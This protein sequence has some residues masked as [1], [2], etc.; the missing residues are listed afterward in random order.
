MP[1]GVYK[2]IPGV[3]SGLNKGKKFTD[4]QK[5]RLSEIAK[6]KGFGK[7]MKGKVGVNKGKVFSKKWREN[8]S[9]AHK[10]QTSWCKGKQN[11]KLYGKKNHNWKGDSAGKVSIHLW[12]RR[13]KGK[14]QEC[15]LCGRTVK[16]TIIDYAN[17][18]HK[19]RR[20]L[21]DYTPL[22]RKCH[23]KYDYT[24]HLSNKGSKWGSISNKL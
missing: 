11:P 18:D 13:H 20:N 5:K 1:S 12:V 17:I 2:R 21:N 3:N 8:L 24:N 23:R 6:K 16:E 10:G 7:W 4:E 15:K 14:P 9:K 22:C 19:Y